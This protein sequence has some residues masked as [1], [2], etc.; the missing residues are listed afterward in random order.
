MRRPRDPGTGLERRAIPPGSPS[1]SIRGRE[2][3]SCAV[4]LSGRPAAAIRPARSEC[5][6][7]LSAIRRPTLIVNAKDDPFMGPD[8]L[9]KLEDLSPYVN[10]ECPETGG[11]VG[12]I[13]TGR[14]G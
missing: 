12:F 1:Q 8:I 11:H 3:K 14:L 13:S 6:P 2:A 10:L 4:D 5:G 7:F 9:P